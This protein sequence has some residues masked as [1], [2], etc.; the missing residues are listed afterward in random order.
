MQ[1]SDWCA[2]LEFA[3]GAVNLVL[4]AQEQGC[5]VIP[6][7]T[8]RTGDVFHYCVLS[9]YRENY[10]I[11]LYKQWVWNGVLVSTT[12][13]LLERKSCGSGLE[14]ENTVVGIRHAEHS[15]PSIH[16]RCH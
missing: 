5:P 16:K 3:N 10:S 2:P 1:F 13:E 11:E 8:D 12:E 14:T 7:G 4:Q 9:R 15:T 6:L